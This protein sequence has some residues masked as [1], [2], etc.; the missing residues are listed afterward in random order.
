MKEEILLI[1]IAFT[2]CLG[3]AIIIFKALLN[4]IPKKFKYAKILTIVSCI[5]YW[6]F[7]IVVVNIP[8]TS[9]EFYE[10]VPFEDGQYI[11]LTMEEDASGSAI[12]QYKENGTTTYRYVRILPYD[13]GYFF[14][15]EETINQVT[16]K[17]DNDYYLIVGDGLPSGIDKTLTRT[18][19]WSLFS[20][21]TASSTEGWIINVSKDEVLS[22]ADSIW[23]IK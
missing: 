5:L 10:L 21:I 2:L 1:I 22:I 16:I 4:L 15:A 14:D 18:E 19:V 9:Y 17:D 13:R 20:A 23:P 6:G 11:Q 7:F 3:V 8:I 12:F